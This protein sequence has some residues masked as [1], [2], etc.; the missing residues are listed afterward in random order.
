MY[1]WCIG[2]DNWS[3]ICTSDVG[4]DLHIGSMKFCHLNR[5]E[6][7]AVQKRIAEKKEALKQQKA[8]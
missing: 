5:E 8:Q 1:N 6:M 7:V 4:V 3:Y 2:V